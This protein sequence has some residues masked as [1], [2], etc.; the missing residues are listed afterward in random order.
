MA[1]DR[2]TGPDTPTTVLIVDDHPAVRDAIRL[3][4][5]TQRGVRVIAAASSVAEAVALLPDQR[6]AVILLDISLP[7]ESGIDAIPVFRR[8]DPGARVVMY[9]LH[10]EPAYAQAA[11]REGADGYV[12]KDDPASL[13]DAVAS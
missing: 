3:L 6:P 9:S 5:E 2:R 1:A 8:L 7:G 12:V 11:L 13:L 4:L 10:D